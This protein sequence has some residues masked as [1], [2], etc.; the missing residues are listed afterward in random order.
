MKIKKS[1]ARFSAIVGIGEKI[2][3]LSKE[4]GKEYLYLNRGI[5]AV[6]PIDL[7][8]VVQNISI[9]ESSHIATMQ[10]QIY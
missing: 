1:G 6:C 3:Q 2:K 5:N 4:T 9:E 10:K 7:F 8:Q